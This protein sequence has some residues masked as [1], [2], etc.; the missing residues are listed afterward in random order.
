MLKR[1]IIAFAILAL[2]AAFAGTV[3]THGPAYAVTLVQPTVVGGT[4]LKP[5]EYRLTLDGNKATLMLG[6][7]AVSADV[8][9]QTQDRKIDTTTL[10]FEE[11]AGKQNLR[12]V[13]LGGTKITLLFE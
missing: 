7:Q 10:R 2:A 9:V 1:F 11:V 5:G 12:E 3:P 6:K 4:V 8:K 13:R